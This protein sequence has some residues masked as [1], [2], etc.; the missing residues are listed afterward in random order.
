LNRYRTLVPDIKNELDRWLPV[1]AA[2]RLN[3]DIQP[4]R[5]ALLQMVQAG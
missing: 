5:E 2:A 3:E 1:I 4:E